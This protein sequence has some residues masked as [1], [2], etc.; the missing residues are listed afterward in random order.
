MFKFPSAQREGTLNVFSAIFI[1]PLPNTASMKDIP[2]ETVSTASYCFQKKRKEIVIQSHEVLSRVWIDAFEHKPL[3]KVDFE[4]QC[5]VGVFYGE[6]PTTGYGVQVSSITNEGDRIVVRVRLTRPQA[7]AENR[8]S[9][10]YHVVRCPYLTKQVVF[11]Y[12]S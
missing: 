4:N 6:R 1:I 7:M 2:F 3:P 9:Q 12:L 10:P 11:K 8:V 5:L